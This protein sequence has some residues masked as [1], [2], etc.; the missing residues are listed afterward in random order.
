MWQFTKYAVK[1]ENHSPHTPRS[2]TTYQNPLLKISLAQVQKICTPYCAHTSRQTG[3]CQGQK[4]VVSYEGLQ[5]SEQSLPVQQK[6]RL[7]V[8][9]SS[10]EGHRK[11]SVRAGPGR[12]LRPPACASA[13]PG[14]LLHCW[15]GAA[16]HCSR[17]KASLLHG[18]SHG[19]I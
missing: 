10:T 4:S 8:M 16:C 18:Q 5:W 17:Y 9:C 13:C 3:V 7:C 1:K 6:R 2:T 11:D 14:P 12:F 19:C 15:A